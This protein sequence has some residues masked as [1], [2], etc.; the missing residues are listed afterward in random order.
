MSA[1]NINAEVDAEVVDAEAVKAVDAKAEDAGRVVRTPEEA[2][3]IKA[4]LHKMRVQSDKNSEEIKAFVLH[5]CNKPVS[6][7]SV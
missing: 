2:E 6:K 7:Q 1:I 4:F 5:M 3:A